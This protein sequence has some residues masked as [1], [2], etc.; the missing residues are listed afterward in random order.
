MV[1]ISNFSEQSDNLSEVKQVKDDQS[2]SNFLP[3]Q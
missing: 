3:K 2:A 1:K